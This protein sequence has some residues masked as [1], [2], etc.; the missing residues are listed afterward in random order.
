MDKNQL[1]GLLALKLV[2]EKRNFTAAAQIRGSIELS[3]PG[4]GTA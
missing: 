4:G 3:R 2:A 1:D